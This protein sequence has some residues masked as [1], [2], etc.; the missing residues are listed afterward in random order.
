MIL[1]GGCLDFT[2]VISRNEKIRSGVGCGW[3]P[4]SATMSATVVVGTTTVADI[5]ALP[6]IQ[7]QPT[8]LRIFSFL[9]MTGVKS[10]Q[11]PT[12]IITAATA[13]I[14]SLRAKDRLAGFS[15][16]APYSTTPELLRRTA[17]TARRN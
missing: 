4:G 7:P 8:P 17:Q 13:K 14:K 5:V 1:V 3:I 6:G 12:K 10:K 2:P 11:P 9:E 16:H 15:P